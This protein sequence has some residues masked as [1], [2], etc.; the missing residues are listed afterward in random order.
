M[1]RLVENSMLD[2]NLNLNQKDVCNAPNK[3]NSN[4]HY[5]D[6]AAPIIVLLLKLV[7][8]QTQMLKIDTVHFLKEKAY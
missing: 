6:F 4:L 1:N 8:T 7:D 3:I 2:S 5:Q